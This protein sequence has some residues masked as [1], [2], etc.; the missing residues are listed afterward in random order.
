MLSFARLS[1]RHHIT[2]SDHYLSSI[3]VLSKG[4]EIHRPSQ[5]KLRGS[6]T[7]EG[8]QKTTARWEVVVKST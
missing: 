7:Y 6:K 3:K 8:V 1:C 2:T 4:G 5:V